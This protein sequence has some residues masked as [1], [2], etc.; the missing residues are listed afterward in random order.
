MPG[1]VTDPCT[2]FAVLLPHLIAA[3]FPWT[4]R[5]RRCQLP[6]PF[7]SADGLQLDTSTRDPTSQQLSSI[8]ELWLSRL[9]FDLFT[10][11]IGQLDSRDRPGQ[12]SRGLRGLRSPSCTFRHRI[13]GGD[14]TD[15]APCTLQSAP[16]L[17]VTFPCAVVY[18]AFSSYISTRIML[19]SLPSLTLDHTTGSVMSLI[20]HDHALREQP[21]RMKQTKQGILLCHSN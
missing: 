1:H 10:K 16:P 13:V 11:L 18:L 5:R 17:H 12:P 4:C 8:V 9:L 14:P 6:V 15:Y 21:K 7:P 19:R 3:D 2:S 20:T